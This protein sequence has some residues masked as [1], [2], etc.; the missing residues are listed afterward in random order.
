VR[1]YVRPLLLATL[2]LMIAG[3]ALA[4]GDKKCAADQKAASGQKACA[5]GDQKACAAGGQKACAAG[6]AQKF[7]TAITVKKCTPVAKLAKDP[8]RLAGRKVLISGTVKEVCQGRGC[9]V[10]VEADGASFIARSLDE[11]VLLP[12]DCKGRKVVVQGVV[13]PLPPAARAEEPAAGEPAHAC[14]KPE[15]VLATEGVELR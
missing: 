15:W 3:A 14:P 2:A 4:G 7:G 9:W 5:A 10:E 11:S 6:D 8:A 13:K 12:K 1:K